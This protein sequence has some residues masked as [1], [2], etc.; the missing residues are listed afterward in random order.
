MGQ[1]AS[2]FLVVEVAQLSKDLFQRG[3]LFFT[4]NQRV[5]TDHFH[6]MDCIGF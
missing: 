4:L 3:N 2:G 5:M 6:K 1:V